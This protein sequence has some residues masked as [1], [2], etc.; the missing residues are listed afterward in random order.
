MPETRT[1]RTFEGEGG[2]TGGRRTE[3]G[4]SEFKLERVANGER[5]R[6]CVGC[7]RMLRCRREHPHPRHPT[8]SSAQTLLRLQLTPATYHPTGPLLTPPYRFPLASAHVE[9][10]P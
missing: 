10:R 8:P 7:S 3:W 9:E 1:S 5:R 2:V 4:G 6:R